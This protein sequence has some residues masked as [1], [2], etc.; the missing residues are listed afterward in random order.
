MPPV[1][2]GVEQHIG[3]PALDAALE[4]RLQRL[5][6]GVDR[7]ERQIVAEQN[8]SML[9]RRAQMAE[10]AGQGVDVLAVDL[11]QLEAREAGI[12]GT[13]HGLDQGALAHAAGAPEQRIVGGQA[14]RE[15]FRVGQEGVAAAVDALEKRQRHPVDAPDRRK[16]PGL[17]L[18]DEGIG[19]RE[20]GHRR[21]DGPKPLQRLGDSLDQSRERFLKVH[22]GA[23]CKGVVAQYSRAKSRD[24][25][26][27]ATRIGAQTG[28]KRPSLGQ[29]G[30]TSN[31]RFRL[32]SG[33]LGGFEMLNSLLVPT[34]LIIGIMYF[35]MIR[36][37]QKRMKEH[38]EMIA[39]IRRGDTVV[40]SGG[41]IGKVTKVDEHELQVEIAEGVRIKIVRSTV[42]EVRGKGE[43]GDDQSKSA[44]P[45]P[46]TSAKSKAASD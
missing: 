19:G 31:E 32:R 43:G 18:I 10:E 11:D 13:M 4:H 7:L 24:K 28:R 29:A 38:R 21:P 33:R 17:G 46:K 22:A 26:L 39:G 3:G 2:G 8:E 9:G 35:L 14:A 12:D 6:G 16:S 36:P 41:I 20:I 44:K 27:F 1:G 40:S 15:A 45:A 30:D 34:V 25:S 42:S 5:V 37:Q 23:R